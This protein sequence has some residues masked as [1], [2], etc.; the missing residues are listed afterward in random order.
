LITAGLL[1]RIYWRHP[2]LFVKPSIQL[3]TYSHIFYQWPLA[4]SSGNYAI[5]LPDP[6]VLSFLVHGYEFIGLLIVSQT[7]HAEARSVWARVTANPLAADANDPASEV[8]LLL[9]GT[10]LVTGIVIYL[11]YVPPTETGLYAVLFTPE[12][13]S[14]ARENSLKLLSSPIP[15][16]VYSFSTAAVAP[17]L[18]A[19]LVIRAFGYFDSWQWGKASVSVA[20]LCGIVVVVSL[21]GAR[22]GPVNILVLSFLVF[23]WRKRLRLPLWGWLAALTT[24]LAPAIMM[25]LL[26]E[27]RGIAD[28]LDLVSNILGRVFTVPFEVGV[29][30]VDFVQLNGFFGPAAV[31]KLAW[32]LGIEA[33][34]APNIIGLEYAFQPLSSISATAG[35]L[36]T[37]YS[38]FGPLGLILAIFGLCLLDVAVV[39]M[40]RIPSHLALPCLAAITL[41]G[42][43]FVQSDYTVV[44]V[45]HGFGLLLALSFLAGKISF[46]LNGMAS[47][48]LRPRIS[49]F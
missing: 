34:N 18:A 29:W 14:V 35:Y 9:F 39:I 30:Y 26:R 5:F 6:Y 16:F 10:L 28:A 37:Y 11:C 17:L 4:I 15:K 7:V 21:T 32:L 48:S 3:L 8:S 27:G 12:L 24:V 20:A 19:M 49:P 42:F 38:Y 13:A 22:S 23:L 45:T 25:T 47:P 44:W 1:L 46:R 2:F 41:T 43:M 33:I 40:A 36:F 31:P